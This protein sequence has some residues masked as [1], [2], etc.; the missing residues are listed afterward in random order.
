MI[1]AIAG[2][3][4]TAPNVNASNSAAKIR[5]YMISLSLDGLL[6]VDFRI[7]ISILPAAVKPETSNHLFEQDTKGILA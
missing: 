1:V 7:S 6:G 3:G 5:L 2:A 4:H